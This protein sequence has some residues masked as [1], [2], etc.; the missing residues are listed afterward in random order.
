[1]AMALDTFKICIIS[2]FLAT[3]LN[4]NSQQNNQ[5]S[6]CETFADFRVLSSSI[7][8]D[9]GW[10]W[11]ITEYGAGKSC[12]AAE[13]VLQ[14]NPLCIYPRLLWFQHPNSKHREWF[15]IMLLDQ[16]LLEK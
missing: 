1:M 13:P 12:P 6:P 11:D 14:A 4:V 5:S 7:M 3:F 10:L 15:D 8:A 16:S 9:S 2:T